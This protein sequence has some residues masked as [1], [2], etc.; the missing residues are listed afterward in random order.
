MLFRLPH[1]NRTYFQCEVAICNGGCAFPDCSA[2]PSDRLRVAGGPVSSVKGAE[3]GVDLFE[4]PEDDAVTTSTS[5]FVAQP[6]TPEYCKSP[7]SLLVRQ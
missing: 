4:A 3:T 7:F 6:G 5:V 1:A 2:D